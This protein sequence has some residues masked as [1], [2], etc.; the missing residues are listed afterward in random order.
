MLYVTF[1]S[2][3]SN[4][5]GISVAVLLLAIFQFLRTSEQPRPPHA[6]ALSAFPLILILFLVALSLVLAPVGFALLYERDDRRSNYVGEKLLLASFW[7][8]SVSGY[9]IQYKF[10]SSFC[11]SGTCDWVSV[12]GT[13]RHTGGL[14]HFPDRLYALWSY[15]K[16]RSSVKAGEE[17]LSQHTWRTAQRAPTSGLRSVL[18]HRS[19]S[20]LDGRQLVRFYIFPGAS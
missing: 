11:S 7:V 10:S 9:C 19:L 4:G 1:H 13:G 15:H 2:L 14:V 12:A 16:S 8:R 3:E 6:R 5:Y 17:P 20:V 18:R